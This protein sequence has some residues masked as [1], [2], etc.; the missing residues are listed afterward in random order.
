MKE[1]PFL[2]LTGLLFLA[3]TAFD[4]YN[5][6]QQ[7]AY[8]DPDS[9]ERDHLSLEQRLGYAILTNA[10]YATVELPPEE[11][12]KTTGTLTFT[13]HPE[14]P[15]FRCI[16]ETTRMAEDE[17]DKV[18][19]F[20]LLV[21]ILAAEKYNRP[22]FIRASEALLARAAYSTTGRTP[23]F[24]LGL[25]QIRPSI[26]QAELTE[27]LGEL[28]LSGGALL[29]YALNDCTNVVAADHHVQA[30]LKKVDPAL[31][32]EQ[33]VAAVAR[34]YN[35]ASASGEDGRMYEMSV[36]G[37]YDLLTGRG[38]AEGE[39]M[40][41]QP[42]GFVACA[43]FSV[44]SPVGRSDGAENDESSWPSPELKDKLA[45]ATQIIVSFVD[46]EPGPAQYRDRVATLRS[47]WVVQ[48]LV[49]AGVSASVIQLEFAEESVCS[50]TGTTA[51]LVALPAQDAAAPD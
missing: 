2:I 34:A 48:H 50:G 10:G 20:Q 28:D 21:S 29:D 15:D 43:L 13:P 17:M 1:L 16:D 25:A 9:V 6:E 30:L 14:H 22:A 46:R 38:N 47:D 45:A 39:E 26:V 49:A 3:S 8:E 44:G 31:P 51:T 4:G 12:L 18:N 37:A 36:V 42:P 33:A 41:A 24:S 27:E 32:V 35:G 7:T 19:A 5:T 40:V 11:E 23:D